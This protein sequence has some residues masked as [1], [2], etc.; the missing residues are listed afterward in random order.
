[1]AE[2]SGRHFVHVFALEVDPAWRRRSAEERRAD[3]AELAAAAA[4][5]AGRVTTYT[6][7]MIGTRA[8]ASI[9]FWRLGASFRARGDGG[10]SF[11]PASERGGQIGTR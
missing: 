9:L 4:R 5:S 10:S 1:M 7:S 2:M 8:D 6:Y 11:A 3:A